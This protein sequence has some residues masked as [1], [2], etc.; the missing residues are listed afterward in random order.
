MKVGLI[1]LRLEIYIQEKI[2]GWVF[3]KTI[4][5]ILTVKGLRNAA[6][7]VKHNEE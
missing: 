3:D 1:L 2:I 4:D 5:K 7:N 6:L